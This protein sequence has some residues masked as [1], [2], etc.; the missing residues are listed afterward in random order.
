[1]L[2]GTEMG[3]RF[4]KQGKG[5]VVTFRNGMSSSDRRSGVPWRSEREMMPFKGTKQTGVIM[6]EDPNAKRRLGSLPD[7]HTVY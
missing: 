5:N 7:R 1:M 2:R 4:P 3:Q 6:P